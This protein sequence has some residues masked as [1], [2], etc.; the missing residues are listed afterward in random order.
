MRNVFE[1]ANASW[2]AFL[3][4][5]NRCNSSCMVIREGIFANCTM[6]S[7]LNGVKRYSIARFLKDLSN[8][9]SLDLLISKRCSAADVDVT[10]SLE[11][12]DLWSSGLIVSY[13]FRYHFPN[14]V[15]AKD[16]ASAIKT[17]CSSLE[18][19]NYL[20]KVSYPPGPKD[21]TC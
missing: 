14:L 21:I 4:S 9:I 18:L 7:N 5:L 20:V 2:R 11:G 17:I 8:L 10:G 1:L 15:P 3:V 16:S 19:V 12:P 13:Y 6:M